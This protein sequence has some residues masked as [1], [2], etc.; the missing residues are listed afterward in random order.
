MGNSIVL[1]QYIPTVCEKITKV[2]IYPAV[3]GSVDL[4][5]VSFGKREG[6]DNFV[7]LTPD[8]QQIIL[9]RNQAIADRMNL[10]DDARLKT[11][12]KPFWTD[13]ADSNVTFNIVGRRAALAR[14]SQD[15][16]ET[17]IDV[18]WNLFIPYFYQIKI[19]PLV[20]PEI[21]DIFAGTVFYFLALAIKHARVPR[22]EL[23]SIVIDRYKVEPEL[24]LASLDIFNKP[25]IYNIRPTRIWLERIS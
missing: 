10:L 2:V 1:K 21:L 20:H 25:N 6:E 9:H 7:L 14:M 4:P 19:L 15:G 18:H 12:L 5:D 17:I 23:R 8:Q 11:L 16:K 13:I 3:A 22:N 24:L